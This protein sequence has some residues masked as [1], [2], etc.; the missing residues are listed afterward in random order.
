MKKALCFIMTAALLA[1]SLVGCGG[2]GGASSTPTQAAGGSE[3]AGGGSGGSSGGSAQAAAGKTTADGKY[4]LVFWVYSDA[5]LNDQGKLFDQWVKEYCEENENVNSITLIGKNDSDLLTS[6][7]AGVGLPDMFFASA[8][9][10]VQY[11]GAIDLL[12]LSSIYAEPEYKDGFYPAAIDAIS[13]DGAMWAVPF[14]SYVP[15]IFRNTDVMTKA[16]IDWE[17]EDLTS[18]DKFY[19]ECE[20]V[21]AAGIDATHSWAQGGYYCPGAILACDAQNMTAG[22]ENGETTLK[23]DQLVRTFETV[24]KLEEY[25]NGMSYDDEAAA[26]AFKA[27][28]LAFIAA[29]PWNEPDYKNAGVNYDIQLI[30]SY[31]ENGYT[32]GLQGWDFMYGVNTGDEGRNE[33]IRGWLKKMGS[34]EVQQKF[35]QVIGRSMLRQDAMDAP[36]TQQTEMLTI[37]AK[38]LK[39]GMNQMDFGHS[40]VFWTSAIAD[41]APSVANGSITPEQAAEQ[42]IE[43]INGLYAEAGE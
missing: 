42:F 31:D 40:S 41:V 21:K 30:P 22:V 27:G 18:W 1:G 15:I 12:D 20:K 11:K 19:E 28:E 36:E 9:D 29:G 6:L 23:A 5:V 32:G 8:R 10:M 3:A 35:A 16:G 33:A 26:E 2:S 37:L 17:N 14:M 25:S 24:K 39:C 13:E 38:G 4:D 34:F 43:G 7:M